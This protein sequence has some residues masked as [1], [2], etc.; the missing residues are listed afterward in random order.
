MTIDAWLITPTI[1][2]RIII[3]SKVA[4]STIILKT[5]GKAIPIYAFRSFT[6]SI[7]KNPTLLSSFA[8][9][10]LEITNNYI[11]KIVV[12]EVKK[13]KAIPDVPISALMASDHTKSKCKNGKNIWQHIA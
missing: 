8:S 10:I 9:S 6:V 2:I 7:V 3:T 1:P 4:N 5:F 12:Y 11:T 13:A